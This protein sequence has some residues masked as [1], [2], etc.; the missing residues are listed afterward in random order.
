[1]CGEGL[2][3]GAYV[4]L[5][6]CVCVFVCVCVRARACVCMYARVS[7]C[8]CACGVWCVCVQR[9]RSRS[10]RRTVLR[11]GVLWCAAVSRGLLALHSAELNVH[12]CRADMSNGE[13]PAQLILR[14]RMAEQR[15]SGSA[16]T[17]SA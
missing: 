3:A 2:F 13:R 15:V 7:A 10:L 1:M 9:T 14:D 4:C 16:F 6:V 17:R 8:A 11:C 12:S 5:C